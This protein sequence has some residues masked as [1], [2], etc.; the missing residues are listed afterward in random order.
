M[1]VQL[2]PQGQSP[3]A[4][5]PERYKTNIKR[6][7]QTGN[8]IIAIHFKNN[9]MLYTNFANPKIGSKGFFDNNEE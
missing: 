2:Y 8:S 6:N 1:G 5:R 4:P 9:H 3:C 7:N